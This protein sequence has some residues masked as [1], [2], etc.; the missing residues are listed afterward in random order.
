M[1]EPPPE[2]K[3]AGSEDPEA[4]AE[5][6]LDESEQRTASRE[7]APSSRVEHRTSDESTPPA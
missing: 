1:R 3:A 5:A 2:E 7:S 6:I 4:Q